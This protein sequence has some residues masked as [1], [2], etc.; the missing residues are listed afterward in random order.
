MATTAEQVAAHLL[1]ID[2]AR[3]TAGRA[4]AEH[5]R[6]RLP[7]AA[8]V[9]RRHGARTVYLFG[10]LLDDTRAPRDV[11]LAVAGLPSSRYFRAL[12]D[13]MEVFG[14]P[15]DL[16]RLEDAPGSLRERIES[17]GVAL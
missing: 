15:V 9:L 4:R 10:S 14:G 6:E 8:S 1:R 3:R 7:E 16:V 2:A 11:D 17:E 13:L 12:A 5:L